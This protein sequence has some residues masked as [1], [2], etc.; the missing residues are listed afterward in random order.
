MLSLAV[1]LCVVATLQAWMSFGGR[2]M[3]GHGLLGAVVLACAILQPLPAVFCRPDAA[4]QPERRRIFNL[5]HRTGG[6]L[7]LLLATVTIFL[8]V[9]NYRELWDS[10]EAQTFMI[11]VVVCLLS[12]AGA[13]GYVAAGGRK[14]RKQ[15]GDSPATAAS[16]ASAKPE[17]V[18]APSSTM[19]EAISS[20]SRGDLE[21]GIKTAPH[22]QV[23]SWHE[24][25]TQLQD[26]PMDGLEPG[27]APLGI[28][29]PS[30]SALV[31][32]SSSSVSITAIAAEEAHMEAPHNSSAGV[33]EQFEPS[34]T[35]GAAS[36]AT[37]SDRRGTTGAASEEDASPVA[38]IVSDIVSTYMLSSRSAPMR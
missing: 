26:V 23:L 34:W 36:E 28:A 7:T 25:T 32:A 22:V 5:A 18:Q 17:A 33:P 6:V 37:G 16:A 29:P 2:A 19:L 35:P 30:G 13:I 8:G 38:E 9:A 10:K 1:V 31:C 20:R 14:V 24:L 4:R 3:H 15:Q 21:E 27:V 11:A 12:G